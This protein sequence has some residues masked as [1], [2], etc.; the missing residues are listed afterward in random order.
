M[1]GLLEYLHDLVPP[2]IHRDI[3]P[4]NI[5][6]RGAESW[7]PVLVDFDTVAAPEGQRTGITVVGTP[8]YAA[9]EQF[10][11]DASP[12]SDL[13]GLGATMLFV[14]THVEPDALPRRDGRF[15]VDHL[16][17][18][19]DAATRKVLLRLVEPEKRARYQHARD[20]LNDLRAP[21]KK[22]TLPPPAR[23]LPPL[24]SETPEPAPT[25]ALA[26]AARLVPTKPV[27]LE[28]QTF[29]ARLDRASLAKLTV[30]IFAAIVG[31]VYVTQAGWDH[32][33]VDQG[34]RGFVQDLPAPAPPCS[35]HGSLNACMD[36]AQAAPDPATAAG[37]LT[38]ACNVWG[39]QNDQ[40]CLRLAA[41]YTTG[42]GVA[43]DDHK[44]MQL[45]LA[46]CRHELGDLAA[47]GQA[48][49]LCASDPS[50]LPNGCTGCA[51]CTAF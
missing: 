28:P 7:D 29:W 38:S 4:A 2:V 14:A 5:M 37:E 6:F 9:P 13:Y 42:Y 40:P 32:P 26:P 34:Q 11:G 24:E 18:S 27:K 20:A 51:E 22:P 46:A 1:L 35:I 33:E 8:G 39:D 30:V 45:Y 44:A 19:L 41:W 47:C 15:D 17:G 23:R 31:I 25:P 49:Q 12:A 43:K 10:A 50:T 3:K 48:R 16:L 36:L 21:V